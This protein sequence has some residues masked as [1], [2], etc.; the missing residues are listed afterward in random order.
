MPIGLLVL[1]GKQRLSVPAQDLS[2]GQGPLTGCL[3]LKVYPPSNQLA[4][5]LQTNA[6]PIP[7]PQFSG[8]PSLESK[9]S[10]ELYTRSDGIHSILVNGLQ[11][12]RGQCS[13]LFTFVSENLA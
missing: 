5:S 10:A 8:I 9:N 12:S 1:L 13:V 3:H 4:F 6:Q 11:A 2:A 7:H